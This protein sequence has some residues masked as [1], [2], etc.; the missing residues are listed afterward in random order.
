MIA[1]FLLALLEHPRELR[2]LRADPSLVPA[3]VEELLRF[4][5]V[6]DGA[7]ALVRVALDDTELGGQ[8]I[9]KGDAVIPSVAAANRDPGYFPDAE[10]LDVSRR[11]TGMLAFGGGH[12]FC[13][14]AALARIELQEALTALLRHLP[15]GLRLAVGH[16]ELSCE[17]SASVRR[18]R[19]FPLSW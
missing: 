4:I 18:L 14:G 1:L 13:V 8:R 17:P 2:R 15:D 6:S 11:P 10:V 12:H 3:A 19:E 7:S 5:P 16:S 9:A